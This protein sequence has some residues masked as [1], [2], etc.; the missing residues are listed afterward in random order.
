MKL[1]VR[2][3]SLVH[4]QGEPTET[5]ALRSASLSLRSGNPTIISGANGSGKTTLLKIISGTL[6]PTSGSVRLH[7]GDRE[8]EVDTV[9]L[10][11]NVEHV[12]QQPEDGLFPELSLMENF[13][14]RIPSRDRRLFD[15]YWASERFR[16]A[17][18]RMEKLTSFYGEY[19]QRRLRSLSGGEKKLFAIALANV[20]PRP[21]ILL[22]EP[23]SGLDP[24]A[25]QKIERRLADWL[26]QT[27]K[28]ALL[29]THDLSLGNRLG[30]DTVK[31]PKID[32]EGA[33]S[34]SGSI[35]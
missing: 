27:D 20:L 28:I 18:S 29:V 14:L 2:N 35:P 10:K 25:N 32:P 15:P 1:S 8:R 21:I 34:N 9:W 13:A 26:K 6:S 17:E 3:I 24:T 12:F 33:V 5:M 31:M 16:R 11:R 22:D 4:N 7:E 30:F 23:T 19:R